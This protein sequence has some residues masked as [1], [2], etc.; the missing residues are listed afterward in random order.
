LARWCGGAGIGGQRQRIADMLCLSSSWT[1][2]GFVSPPSSS[3]GWCVFAVK[4]VRN[5]FGNRTTKS[6]RT[7][8]DSQT[9]LSDFTS[10][11]ASCKMSSGDKQPTRCS[12]LSPQD[13]H[14]FTHWQRLFS[15]PHRVSTLSTSAP[16]SPSPSNPPTK[17]TLPASPAEKDGRTKDCIRVVNHLYRHSPIIIFLN[18]QLQ[19]L[20]CNPPIWCQHCEDLW[21]G[22]FSTQAGIML[23]QNRIWNERTVESTLAH[24][25]IHAFD[26]CRFKMDVNNLQH[27]ACSEVPTPRKLNLQA[28]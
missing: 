4:K 21:R 7:I 16:P 12:A 3:C 18:S 19:K 26:Y 13:Q 15:H 10:T 25:M 17:D 20:G 2:L 28:R 22:G 11:F 27:V 5:F 8:P 6:E 9:S 14:V 1:A 24:E 23:C